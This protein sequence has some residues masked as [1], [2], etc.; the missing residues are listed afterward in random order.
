MLLENNFLLDMI[1][2]GIIFIAYAIGIRIAYKKWKKIKKLKRE[3][4][5]LKKE[6]Y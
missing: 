1:L 5:E 3:N 2:L 4:K 6:L